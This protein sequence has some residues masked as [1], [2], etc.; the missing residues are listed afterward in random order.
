MKYVIV[1]KKKCIGCG[2]CVYI[3]PNIFQL[4]KDGKSKVINQDVKSIKK[5][6]EAISSCPV[7]AISYK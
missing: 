7:G 6:D 4:G 1:D 3:A 5:I 2:T